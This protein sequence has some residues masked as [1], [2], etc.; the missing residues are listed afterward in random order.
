MKPIWLHFKPVGLHTKNSLNFLC[1][2]DTKGHVKPVG[3]HLKAM[4]LHVKARVNVYV[5]V[6]T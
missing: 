2:T 3:S 5:K 4:E 1:E 6:P